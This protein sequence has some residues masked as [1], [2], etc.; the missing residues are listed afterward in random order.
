[1]HRI[2]KYSTTSDMDSKFPVSGFGIVD[3]IMYVGSEAIR[4]GTP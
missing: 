2:V 3:K 4:E 1:M